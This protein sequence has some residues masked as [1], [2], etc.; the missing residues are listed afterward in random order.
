MWLVLTALAALSVTALR[1][2]AAPGDKYKLGFLSLV[3]WG[4]TLMW[5]VEH[6]I[7]YAQGSG[8]FFEISVEAAG[9][10]LAVIALGLL[11]WLVRLLVGD[12]GR[13]VRAVLKK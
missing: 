1:Y 10:G 12:H 4:A 13:I 11:M 6:V 9:L 5:L 7:A 2:M 8:P 3:Y